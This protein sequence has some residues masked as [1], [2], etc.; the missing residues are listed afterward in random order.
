MAERQLQFGKTSKNI[1]SAFFDAESQALRVV[2]HSGHSGVYPGTTEQEALDFER[3]DS[4]GSHH[5]TF[6]KKAGRTYN[7]IG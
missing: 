3:A 5:D 4:P 2:F 7:R 1:H 6:F